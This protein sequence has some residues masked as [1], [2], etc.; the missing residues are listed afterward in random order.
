VPDIQ[1]PTA[2]EML[3]REVI[4]FL[5]DPTPEV[6][7]IRGKWGTGKTYA[8]TKYLS[9]AKNAGQIGLERYSY[10][11]LFGLQSLDQ[12][13]NT[14]FE[15]T[16]DRKSIGIEP[17]LATVKD[18][19][20]DVARQLGRKGLKS[21]LELGSSL[22]AGAKNAVAPLQSLAFHFVKDQIICIDDLERKGKDLRSI[23]I[24]GLISFLRERR[25]C[26]VVLILND[27]ELSEEDKVALEKYQEKVIDISLLFAPTEEE[28]QSPCPT[29][30]PGLW[31]C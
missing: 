16:I 19:A 7:C 28:L 15:N 11:S 9:E 2:T 17:S 4:R 24:F 12:L 26:K 20:L 6:L 14:I 18:N 8:W 22:Y 30:R 5:S 13:K 23:D 1:Q 27:E 3:K 29:G 21:V 31:R 25:R 10:V